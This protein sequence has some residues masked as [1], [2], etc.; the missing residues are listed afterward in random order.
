MNKRLAAWAKDR[1]NV[2]LVPMAEMLRKLIVDEPLTVAGT[3]YGQGSKARLLQ[4]DNLHTTLEGTCALWLLAVEAWRAQDPTL[5]ADA[6]LMDVPAL[7]AKAQA[8]P[9]P[10]QKGKA[11]RAKPAEKKTGQGT[12]S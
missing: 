4:A 1:K 8:A 11:K 10:P 5:P 2:V 6:I 9:A 12:G 7:V 3:T